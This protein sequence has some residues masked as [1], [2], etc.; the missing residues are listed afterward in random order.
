MKQDE[1]IGNVS[2]YHR[3]DCHILRNS[4]SNQLMRFQSWGGAVAEGMKPCGVCNPF[5]EMMEIV[6]GNV[7]TYHRPDCHILRNVDRYRLKKFQTWEEAV[8][9]G[10]KPCGVCRPTFFPL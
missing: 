5:F 4:R 2:T 3:P 8:A 10:M 9:E 1:V 6:I 7:F